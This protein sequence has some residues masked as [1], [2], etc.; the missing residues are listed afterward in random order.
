MSIKRQVTTIM[1]FAVVSLIN[2]SVILTLSIIY[3]WS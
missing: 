2:Y 3:R 1:P